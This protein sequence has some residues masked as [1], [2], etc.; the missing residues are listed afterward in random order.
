M[1]KKI[2]IF[3]LLIIPYFSIVN[4]NEELEEDIS[5]EQLEEE[6]INSPSIKDVKEINKA[7]SVKIRILNKVTAKSY[8]Y[9]AKMNEMVE[10][11][12]IKIFPLFCWKSAPSDVPENKILIKVYETMM[13]KQEK[14]LFYGWLFSSSP[15]SN[16]VEHPVYDIT[17]VDCYR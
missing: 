6:E 7:K 13:N 4:A 15:G 11:E 14:Q 12:K 17:L 3:F 1:K 10:F 8:S 9:K 5:M 2:S 16:G